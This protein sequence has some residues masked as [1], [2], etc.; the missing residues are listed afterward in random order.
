[1]VCDAYLLGSDGDGVTVVNGDVKM[2]VKVA[3]E[4]GKVNDSAGQPALEAG[5]GI[6]GNDEVVSDRILAAEDFQL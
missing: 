3:F 1:M 6:A 4:K 2:A 5:W